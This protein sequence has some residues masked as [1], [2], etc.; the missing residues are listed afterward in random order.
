MHDIRDIRKDP[1][2]YRRGIARKGG[3]A[4]EIVKIDQLLE[5]DAKRSEITK[6]IEQ[7][8]AEKNKISKRIAALIRSGHS[9]EDARKI[10]NQEIIDADSSGQN[11]QK[12]IIE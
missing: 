10:A 8:R 7:I 12:L 9:L 11:N 5:L 6:L 1:E 2:R 3:S 4:D